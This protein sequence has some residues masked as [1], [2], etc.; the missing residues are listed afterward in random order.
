[1]IEA[2]D[3]W[4][5]VTGASSGFGE[6]FARQYAAQGHSLVLVARRLDR[7][8][9]LA[10]TL[11]EQYDVNVVVEQVDLADIAAII[12]LHERLRERGIAVDILINNAGH[13]LQGPFLDGQMDA[14]LA[15]VQLDIASLTALTHVFAQ[16]MRKRGRGK[17]LL[18]ASLL[19]YY[20]VENFAVYAASKAYV[21]RLGEALHRELKR[22][23]VTVTVLCPGMS[24]T[25]F[26]T[27]A[28]QKLTPILKRVMMQPAP[29]VR[30]GVRALQLGRVSVVPGLANKAVV[31]LA[32]TTPRW[33]NQAIFG[34]VMNG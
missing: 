27:A 33:L 14:A 6:E 26:A 2:H 8:Q 30:A 29:V 4:V 15:M 23:G 1:M 34:R 11:R 32:R 9:K 28:Q 3:S 20:S 18:V 10:E 5:L 24:D 19:A 7:L 31:M 17:I 21:L 13:G 25:G 12:Q 16:H 22:A